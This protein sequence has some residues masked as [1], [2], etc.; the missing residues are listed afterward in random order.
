MAE[1]HLFFF[2]I[3]R[4]LP[5]VKSSKKEIRVF[6]VLLFYFILFYFILFYFILFYFILFYFI[7][8]QGFSV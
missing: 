8:R 1:K 3:I 2:S 7:L 5:S 6:N 4:I